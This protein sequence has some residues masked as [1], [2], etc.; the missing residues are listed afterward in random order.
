MEFPMSRYELEEL[1]DALR[2]AGI[3]AFVTIGSVAGGY[4]FAALV[5]QLSH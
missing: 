5:H 3:V 2:V 1:C 4:L